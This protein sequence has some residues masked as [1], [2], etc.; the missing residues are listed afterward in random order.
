MLVGLSRRAVSAVIATVLSLHTLSPQ[1]RSEFD[2]LMGPA[3][4]SLA[5]SALEVSP[6]SE[7]EAMQ[8]SLY[9]QPPEI[10]NYA[11]QV[12][13]GGKSNLAPA[14]RSLARVKAS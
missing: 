1:Q 3:A 2:G 5:V 9:S 10:Q 8:R 4:W 6:R 13:A 11:Q 12:R 14:R 7:E